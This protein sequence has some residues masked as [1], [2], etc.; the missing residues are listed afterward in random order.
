MVKEAKEKLS[1]RSSKVRDQVRDEG[2]VLCI[3][4]ALSSTGEDAPR[5]AGPHTR[6]F[7][8][9]HS[10]DVGQIRASVLQGLLVAWKFGILG[11][12]VTS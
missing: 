10:I 5:K 9:C 6:R 1:L 4:R 8:S 12:N 3:T 2:G 11:A 7:Q